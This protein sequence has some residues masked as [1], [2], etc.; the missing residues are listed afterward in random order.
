MRSRSA[1]LGIALLVSVLGVGCAWF[2]S[3][4]TPGT[5]SASLED[6]LVELAD[7][8]FGR[9][10]R[11]IWISFSGLEAGDATRALP[12]VGRLAA[13]GVAAD[14]LRVTAPSAVQPAHAT[15]VTGRGPADHGV[16]GDHP[17]GDRGVRPEASV[18]A[19]QLTGPALWQEAQ[20][21]GLGVAA[22]DWPGT[23]GADLPDVLPD[24]LPLRKGERWPELVADRATPWL[25]ERVEAAP[26]SAWLP[27]R[28]RDAFL[29]ETACVLLERQR[30]PAL[31]MLRLSQA[32]AVIALAGPGS[33]SA[34]AALA[35]ADAEVG[36]LL[37][38]ADAAGA[39]EGAA[40]V[41]T[42]D[43]AWFPAHTAV[44]PNVVLAE[45]GLIVRDSA[46][47]V[48]WSSL[49]RSN[50]GSAF[51]YAESARAAVDARR[52][53]TSAADATGAFR[54]VPADEMIELEADPEAW[55]GLDARPGFMFL[56]GAIG[57]L[58]SASPV[59]GTSGRLAEERVGSPA[60]VAF[61]QG[62]RRGVRVPEFDQRDVAPTLAELLG[63]PL[64]R[65]E[66]HA[67]IGGF[68]FERPA[69]PV[70]I[71]PQ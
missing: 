35:R 33:E 30:P 67:L 68:N 17:L 37:A 44:R 11:V 27:G 69:G 62:V 41:V 34:K 20:Q 13:L 31:L 6:R 47:V 23:T 45:A 15:L 22:L 24:L 5:P 56:N 55:F 58:L 40:I 19:S 39:L 42:G 51:V 60:F 59:R 26:V 48:G 12:W 61:G 28:Q 53:L 36:R 38:C 1:S 7:T 10:V 70:P 49:A 64:E 32:P 43:I 4:G 18:H 46:G 65:A 52:A 54:L 50:G 57:P 66:G 71:G 16:T 2:G 63:F 8:G 29:V 3:G 14:D 21:R 25:L 9:P